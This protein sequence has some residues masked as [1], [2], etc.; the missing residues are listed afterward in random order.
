V[1]ICFVVSQFAPVIGGTE[2]QIH[3]LAAGLAARGHAVC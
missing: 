3:Q 1:R 2:G